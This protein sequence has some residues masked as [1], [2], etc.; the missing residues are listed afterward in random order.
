MRALVIVLGF[1]GVVAAFRA[2][3]AVHG[4]AQ[5]RTDAREQ[6]VKLRKARTARR[7][8]AVSAAAGVALLVLALLLAGAALVTAR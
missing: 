2:G 8:A 1:F 5:A 3:Q 7:T 6:R 4:F